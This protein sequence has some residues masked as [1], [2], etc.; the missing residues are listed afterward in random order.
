M[1]LCVSVCMCVCMSVCACVFV[2]VLYCRGRCIVETGH[3]TIY[4]DFTVIDGLHG[5]SVAEHTCHRQSGLATSGPL[6]FAILELHA[7]NGS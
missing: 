6:D 2:C 3:L 4:H 5:L 1:C 7:K